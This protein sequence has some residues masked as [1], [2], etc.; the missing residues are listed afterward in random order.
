[1]FCSRSLK[2]NKIL[3]IVL[4]YEFVKV[5]SA[6]L[7]NKADF[8]T[9]AS[10]IIKNLKRWSYGRSSTI[11]STQRLKT[12]EFNKNFQKLVRSVRME[13]HR[14]AMRVLCLH[15]R[16]IHFCGETFV[17]GRKACASTSKSDKIAA[18]QRY[19]SNRVDHI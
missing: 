18:L 16:S 10:P 14:A 4:M 3:T 2:W 12:C 1:M 13:K 7:S 17:G 11:H 5:L 15:N 8:P 6:N 19:V 9:P